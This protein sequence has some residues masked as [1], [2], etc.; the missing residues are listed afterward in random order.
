MMPVSESTSLNDVL[1]ALGYTTAPLQFQGKRII[2]DDVDVFAGTA[3][4]VW[5]WLR[6]TRQIAPAAR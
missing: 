4:E 1:E 6:K 5:A 3:S 2:R